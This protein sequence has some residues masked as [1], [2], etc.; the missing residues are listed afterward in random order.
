[1][2]TEPTFDSMT[3]AEV[4]EAIKIVADLAHSGGPSPCYVLRGNCVR[5]SEALMRKFWDR[6]RKEKRAGGGR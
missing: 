3:A 4:D 6:T 5:R 1:M 2:S